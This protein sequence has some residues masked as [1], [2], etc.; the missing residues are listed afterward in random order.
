[1][2]GTKSVLLPDRSDAI[3]FIAENE[4]SLSSSRFSSASTDSRTASPAIARHMLA[5]AETTAEQVRH[6]FRRCLAR[7]PSTEELDQL[8]RLFERS[9]KQLASQ[10]DDAVQLAT[11]PLGPLPEGTDAVQAAAGTVVAND[12]LNLDEMMLK[13]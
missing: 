8:V 9:S 5:H 1:M 12:L 10:P 2:L 7:E 4:S 11:L 13:R 3:T 6:G